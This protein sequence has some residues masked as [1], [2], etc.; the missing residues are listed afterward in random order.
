MIKIDIHP[1]F[2]PDTGKWGI[3]GCLIDDTKIT[4][5]DFQ[6]RFD[7]EEEAEKFIAEYCKDYNEKM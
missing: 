5:I 2:L 1:Y 7:S 6:E 3:G 4:E